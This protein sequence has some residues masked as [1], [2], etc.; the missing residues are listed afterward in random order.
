MD[1]SIRFLTGNLTKMVEMAIVSG[2]LA[3]GPVSGSIAR[4]THQQTFETLKEPR[5][6]YEKYAMFPSTMLAVFAKDYILEGIVEPWVKCALVERCMQTT[7]SYDII[8]NCT[9]LVCH[10][11]DQSVVNILIGRLFYDAME[12][13]FLYQCD[14]LFTWRPR[15][16]QTCTHHDLIKR[17]ALPWRL[18]S[19]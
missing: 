17:K 18:I 13:V 3:L 2:I 8:I 19:T 7:E 6:L 16:R 4:Y 1:S 5:C 12:Q 10:R 15:Y 11:Y 9:N 14:I